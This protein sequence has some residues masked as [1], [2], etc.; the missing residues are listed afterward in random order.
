MKPKKDLEETIKEK[1]SSLLEETMEKCWGINIP[2]VESEISDKLSNP[3]LRVYI[4]TSFPF[5]EAKKIFQKEFLKNELRLHKGNIS[6]IAKL[7]EI[8]RRSVHRVVK[9]LEINLEDIRHQHNLGE[10]YQE[11]LIK[12]TIS[13]TLDQYKK[14]IHPQKMEKIYEEVPGLSRNIAKVLPHQH[15]TWKQAEREFEKQFFKEVLKD[16]HW[17]ISR[18]AKKINIRAETLHRKIKQLGIKK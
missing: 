2:K 7:L 15:L 14:L 10:S 5:L 18:T 13:S 4:P 9:D 16:N 8:D 12:E 1:V 11:D 6:Q 3:Q 17:N